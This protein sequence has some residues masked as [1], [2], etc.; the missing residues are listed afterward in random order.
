[1]AV[2]SWSLRSTGATRPS[3]VRDAEWSLVFWCTG[4]EPELYHRASDPGETRNVLRA[5][6][7]E[8]RRLLGEYLRFLRENETPAKHYWSR[9]WLVSWS[10]SDG[11]GRATQARGAA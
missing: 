3:V 2:S 8:A 1:V 4:V 9:R 7:A 5:N 10:R 11:W 6:E